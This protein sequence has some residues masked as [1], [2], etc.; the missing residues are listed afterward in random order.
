LRIL[1]VHQNF[2]AQFRY[3]S[4]A[5]RNA[6]HVVQVVTSSDN[7]QPIQF[8]VVHYAFKKALGEPPP[9]VGGFLETIRQG[10]AASR[11]LL[12]MRDQ[13]FL[14]DLVIGHVGWG[15]SLMV[16]D[17]WPR[18]KLILHAEFYYASDGANINFD[19]EFAK[20]SFD[21]RL[22][23]R[24]NNA[25]IL[26]SL[27]EADRGVA[28][29]EW[30]RSRFPAV[31][32]DRIT[33]VH[34]GIDTELFKPNTE[35]A[36]VLPNGA[37]LR[38]GDE[39]VT[40]VNRNLEPYRGYHQFMRALPEILAARPRAQVV[41]VGGDGNSYGPPA[42]AGTTWKEKFRA[43]V[44]DRLPA[45]RVHFVGKIPYLRYRDLLQVSRA[46]VYL[47]Y[48]F[49]LSWSVLEAMSAGCLLIASRTAPVEEVIVHGENG[50]LFEFFDRVGLVESTVD[51]LARPDAFSN[52]RMAARQTIINRYD[53]DRICLPAWLDLI[54]SV[55]QPRASA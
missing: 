18:T 3:V 24:I 1:F 47:T 22:G 53:R 48:P 44:A 4:V 16:K 13:G 37:V 7:Q 39:V 32:R 6:G 9:L 46:H 41:I 52:L 14:P 2:P 5:L 26:L 54:D 10:H 34:E 36:F 33:V 31:L 38:A 43:E 28:P 27:S 51:A 45:E 12:S 40:F 50:V 29:T 25:P 20:T 17:I 30:Q 55:A 11:A 42:P 8:P 49:V 35:A 23:I 19:P 15:E 21:G